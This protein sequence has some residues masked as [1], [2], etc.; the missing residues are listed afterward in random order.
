MKYR[1]SSHTWPARVVP[2]LT[3]IIPAAVFTVY[4]W[5]VVFAYHRILCNGGVELDSDDSGYAAANGGNGGGQDAHHEARMR[6]H[7][8]HVSGSRRSVR[9]SSYLMMV[10]LLGRALIRAKGL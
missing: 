7:R 8:R 9:C 1:S 2:Y 10:M 3:L 5:R 6:M 4:S